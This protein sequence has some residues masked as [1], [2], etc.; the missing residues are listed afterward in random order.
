MHR[1]CWENKDVLE[2]VGS[3]FPHC[4]MFCILLNNITKLHLQIFYSSFASRTFFSP[5]NISLSKEKVTVTPNSGMTM[6]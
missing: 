4:T 3:Y 5:L 1:I 2:K 6:G